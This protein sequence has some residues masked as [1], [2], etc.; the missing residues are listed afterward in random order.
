MAGVRFAANTCVARD[1]TE[2]SISLRFRDSLKTFTTTLS[3]VVYTVVMEVLTI[4]FTTLVLQLTS[5]VDANSVVDYTILEK[6]RGSEVVCAA[7]PEI[8]SRSRDVDIPLYDSGTFDSNSILSSVTSPNYAQFLRRVAY[9]ET[10]DGTEDHTFRHGYYGGIWQIDEDKF[11]ATLLLQEQHLFKDNFVRNIQNWI[12]AAYHP[13]ITWTAMSWK[14]LLKPRISLL[15]ATFHLLIIEHINKDKLPDGTALNQQ[16]DFWKRHFN[17]SKNVETFVERV[18]ALEALDI[19]ENGR[20]NY[21]TH[22]QTLCTIFIV[23]A[24]YSVFDL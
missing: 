17:S 22:T 18:Q 19:D 11:S 13:D 16:A 7:I 3:V 9:V 23:Y 21:L 20:G 1:S 2:V 24:I 14:D 4:L 5:Y 6:A 12:E 8:E 10:L 15:A